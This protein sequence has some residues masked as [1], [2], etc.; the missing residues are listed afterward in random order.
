MK[1]TCYSEGFSNVARF[2]FDSGIIEHVAEA[3]RCLCAAFVFD[4][5][6]FKADSHLQKNIPFIDKTKEEDIHEMVWAEIKKQMS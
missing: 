3:M 6:H 1:L 2:T 4:H 5:Y